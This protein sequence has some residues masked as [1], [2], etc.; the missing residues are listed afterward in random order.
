MN[1]WSESASVAALAGTILAAIPA[2]RAAN[3][4]RL[5]TKTT[6]PVVQTS[7]KLFAAAKKQVNDKLESWAQDWPP[8]LFRMFVWGLVLLIYAASVDL[9]LK[10]GH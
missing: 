5:R 1:C 3:Y 7:G 6:P 4:L 8:W 2:F 9:G 10:F